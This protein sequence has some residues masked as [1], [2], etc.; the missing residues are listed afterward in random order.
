VYDYIVTAAAYFLFT[1]IIPPIK[2]VCRCE[3]CGHGFDI[4]VRRFGR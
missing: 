2:S 1:M 4:K 3:A